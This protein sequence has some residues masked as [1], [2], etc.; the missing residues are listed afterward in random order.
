MNVQTFRKPVLFSW[1][2]WKIVNLNR[3][4]CLWREILQFAFLSRTINSYPL[5]KQ[6]ALEGI[7]RWTQE[8]A[9]TTIP[10]TCVDFICVSFYIATEKMFG[11]TCWLLVAMCCMVAVQTAKAGES[12]EQYVVKYS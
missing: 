3:K 10:E 9:A 1:N 6:T 12:N 7:T 4:Y 5:D 8:Y 2:V 11:T